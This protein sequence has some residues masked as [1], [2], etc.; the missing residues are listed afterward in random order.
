MSW[1]GEAVYIVWCASE[2]LLARLRRS[3][4]G[5][6]GGDR[7]SLAILWMVIVASVFAAVTL[8]LQTRAEMPGAELLKP[9]G[10]V[11]ILTGVFFR[12]MVVRSLGRAFTV[13]LSVAAGQALHTTGFHRRVRHP[14]YAFSLL[15]FLGFGLSLGNGWSLLVAF[16]PPFLAFRYRIRVEEALLLRHFGEA[17]SA[18]MRRTKRLL[19]WLY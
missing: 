16:V 15:S 13:D 6:Q 3:A 8:S 5:S 1:L 10:F 14:S 17:Y 19:P 11:L 12:L 4:P 9:L 18:Y 7:Y 2:I